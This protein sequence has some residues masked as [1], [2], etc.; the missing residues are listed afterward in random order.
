MPD[1]GLRHL[2]LAGAGGGM[3]KAKWSHV[4]APIKVMKPVLS[5]SA[6]DAG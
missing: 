3:V 1:T 4:A 6:G 2:T 5:A